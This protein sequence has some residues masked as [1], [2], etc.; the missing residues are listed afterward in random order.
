M[1]THSPP[2]R[3]RQITRLWYIFLAWGVFG[4]T[5]GHAKPAVSP[6]RQAATHKHPPP[7]PSS[8]DEYE[9]Q[10]N[11]TVEL[12]HAQ[13]RE[14]LRGI[15]VKDGDSEFYVC[16]P[17]TGATVIQFEKPYPC[18]SAPTG[19]NYTEGIA[20]I[21]KENIAPYKFKATMYYKDVSVAHVWYGSSYAQITD[22]HE[23]RAPVP[24]AEIMDLINDK[25]VCKSSVTYSRHNIETTAFHKD[26]GETEMPLMPA[27]M[28]LTTAK[29]W[30]TVG[31]KYLPSWTTGFHRTG[32]TVDC[33]VEEVEARS[34]YPYKEFVLATGDFVYMSPFYG[35]RDGAHKEHIAYSTDRF[36]Q[37]ENFYLRDLTTKSRATNP[38]TRN[39]LTTPKFTVGWDWV[40]KKPS[41]CT[42]A[43]WQEVDE[44]LRSEHGPSFRFASKTLST[45]FTTNLTE[46]SLSKV[47]LGDCVGQ[48]ARAA[49]ESIYRKKYN[50]T[51][52]RVGDIQYYLA[53][54]GFLIAYQPLLSTSLADLYLQEVI[55]EQSR[56]PTDHKTPVS[57]NPKQNED[58]KTERH[59]IKT[60]SSIEFARLQ[61]TYDHIQQHV[62]EMLGRIAIAWCELQNRE[63][64]LWNEARKLNPAAIASATMGYRVGAR[65]LG[66]VMAVSTCRPIKADNVIMQNSMRVPGKPGTCYS[67]PLVSFKQ[68]DNGPLIEGQLGED[69]EI[70]L[71]RDSLEQ[72][73]V[74]HRRYFTFGSGYVYFEEYTYSHHLSRADITTVSTFVP[75]NI[76]M[77]EDHEFV[78]LE[79]YTRQEIK[80][81]GLLD[82]TE[83]QRRNQLHAL[84]F[85]DIDTIIHPDPYSA[86]F[87][88]LYSFFD[89]LGEIGRAVGRV[90]TGIVGGVV[91]TVEGV[92]SF[93]SNP[94]GALAIGLLVVAGL[95]AAFF[96]FRYV[97]RLQSN[98]MKALYPLTTKEL[99]HEG[100]L[101]LS[102]GGKISSEAG[103]EDGSDFDEK[104][105]Q[106]A[107]EMIRYMAMVSALERTKHKA[108]RKNKDSSLINA[109]LTNMLLRKPSTPKYSPVNETDDET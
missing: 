33:V 57:P 95:V 32:T 92:G 68:E 84:R 106:A 90:V 99:K 97:L 12:G 47:D 30:N 21:F 13:L 10:F 7:P 87:S 83:V 50:S 76:T 86:I 58:P 70:R 11:E 38:S 39:M 2:K 80:D 26:S 103:G 45:T 23:D 37:V 49:I 64:T 42:M 40:P 5:T 104:K 51:H 74:G 94:F 56:K 22:L 96:A 63:L 1:T 78:P 54:G 69:N 72:C 62:N 48:E 20:I 29:G 85:H 3:Q 108:L 75:L 77:M 35:Y 34:V 71:A 44:M 41:V 27:K 19:D 66:D 6:S 105:L 15:K 9:P 24:F 31:L 100:K 60:T 55:K 61:F 88:G 82:Y 91:A 17:P 101:Q 8:S 43:K 79:V 16:P 53:N 36:K 52:L 46:Y 65:M 98:P 73:T 59:V 93:M 18:P 67:R 4:G 25:G 109:G 89:G 102:V 28:T 107:Q 81:S 14:H